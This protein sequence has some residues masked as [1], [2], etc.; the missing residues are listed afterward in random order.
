M[1]QG[2]PT[3]GD[4]VT[5]VR[6]IAAPAGAVIETRPPTDSATATLTAPP[7]LTREGDSVRIAY[8]V[9][10][11]GAGHNDLVLPGAVIVE[12][13]GRVDT[14]ADSHV[15]LN[16][17][18][19]LPVAKSVA[20]ITPKT[21]RPWLPRSYR[22][23]LP[24]AVLLPAAI[25]GVAMLQWWWRRLGP[26]PA[27]IASAPNSAPLTD[28]RVSAWV[29]AGEA[30]LALDHIDWMVRDRAEFADWR[31]R[32]AEVRFAPG[33]DA[34]VAALVAEAWSRLTDQSGRRSTP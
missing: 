1:Q 24:F 14:L 27:A 7:V 2:V 34:T 30:R 33:G 25:I 8:T 12:P 4:T 15:A 23:E 17:A 18:S 9:A 32:A 10:V 31:Q 16:V 29:A 22:S 5:I 28:A 3:V 26:P 21:A 19:V 6:W 11:W 13:N 20:A